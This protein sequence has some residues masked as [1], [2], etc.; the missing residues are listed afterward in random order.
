MARKKPGL[1]NADAKICEAFLAASGEA[2]P[3]PWRAVLGDQV[4]AT[5]TRRSAL[6]EFSAVLGATIEQITA[7]KKL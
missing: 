1:N 5:A 3:R 4:L 6:V 7:D 2:L